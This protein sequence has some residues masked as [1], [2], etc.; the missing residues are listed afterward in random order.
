MQQIVQREVC[1]K[2]NPY[3]AGVKTDLHL[4]GISKGFASLPAAQPEPS[5]DDV[6]DG[7]YSQNDV[8]ILLHDGRVLHVSPTKRGEFRLF[9]PSVGEKTCQDLDCSYVNKKVI[10]GAI[11]KETLEVNGETLYLF[12]VR[13]LMRLLSRMGLKTPAIA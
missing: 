10:E 4:G 5:G 1:F 11:N 12:D 8:H 7:S 2:R 13:P 6:C 3:L 9:L